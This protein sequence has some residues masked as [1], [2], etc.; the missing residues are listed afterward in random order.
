M[1]GRASRRSLPSVATALATAPRTMRRTS[2][3]SASLSSLFL[4]GAKHSKHEN[5]KHCQERNLLHRAN[6][7]RS[8]SLAYSHSAQP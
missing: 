2:A 8:E 7:C 1:R 3:L 4:H 6:C 5:P